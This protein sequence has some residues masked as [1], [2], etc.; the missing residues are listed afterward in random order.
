MA[1]VQ[2]VAVTSFRELSSC[3]MLVLPCQ[4][5]F[6]LCPLTCTNCVFT[7][8]RVTGGEVVWLAAMIEE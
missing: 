2:A 8:E 4:R 6:M 1:V 5:R 3:R 7:V